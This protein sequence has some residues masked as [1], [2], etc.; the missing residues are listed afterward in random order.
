VESLVAQEHPIERIVITV[1]TINF[2]EQPCHDVDVAFLIRYPN[3]VCHRP[4]YDWGPIMKYVGGLDYIEDDALVFVCDDDQHYAPNRV[5]NLVRHWTSLNDPKAIVGWVGAGVQSWH[6]SLFTLHGVRGVL[7][8]KAALVDLYGAVKR[9][10]L[11]RCCAMNDDVL[12]SIQFA[13]AGYRIVDHSGQDDEFTAAENY[14]AEDA[15]HTCYPNHAAKVW[16]I[17]R[18]HWRFNQPFMRLTAGA[19]ML[20]LILVL[21]LVGVPFASARTR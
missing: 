15:L 17:V 11:P 16:D 2:R 14:E 4:N 13:K 12:A 20:L 8:P 21:Y 6:T 1:P 3:V 9:F 10:E 7:V 18:C 5:S 19:A